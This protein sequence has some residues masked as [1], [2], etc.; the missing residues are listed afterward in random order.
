MTPNR[1]LVC[2]ASFI[3]TLTAAWTSWACP[4]CSVGRVARQQ[5]LG[6][7]LAMNLLIALVPFIIVGIVSLWAEQ[8][9]KAR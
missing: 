7:G 4:N 1:A 2:L 5:V 8:I 6:E 9:G 3:A